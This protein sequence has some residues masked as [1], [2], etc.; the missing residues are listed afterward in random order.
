MPLFRI[1]N[2]KVHTVPQADF[3]T[4]KS[5]QHLVEQNLDEIFKCRLVATE[6]STG[7]VHAGRI[8]TL[9]LSEDDNPVVI[10]YKKSVSS[11]LVNQSLFYL[12]WLADHKGD[13][14]IAA[15]RALGAKTRIDWSGI[16]V[17]CVA[18]NYRKY[19]LHAVQMMGQSIELWTYR[20]FEN[21][22]F[23]LEQVHQ[24]GDT[25][26][27]TDKVGKNPVMVAAGKKAAIT[28]RTSSWTIEHHLD[29]KSA[30][31]R[32]IFHGVQEFMLSLDAGIEEAAMKYYVAYRTT[33]NIVCVETQKQK[34]YLFLKLNPKQH[35]GPT[36]KS[37]DV[38]QIGH[39]GTGDLEITLQTAA[40][41]E[42]AKP[43]L[44]A[45]YERVG[46]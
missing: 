42:L 28:K 36:G 46:G 18:P 11:E 21:E 32:E 23:Y 7:A 3:V 16:R 38:S 40:D 12:A 41:V 14:E 45:A 34:V 31:I 44:K 5:L 1:A 25:V 26:P 6:F 24:G 35:P 9:A 19:D 13:F 39:Y 15:Q 27:V 33:Q 20:R 8:D 37:R 4:E 22:T 10:E 2:T 30:L 17:I 43:F 29:G